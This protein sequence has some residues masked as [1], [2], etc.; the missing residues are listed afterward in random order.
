MIWISGIDKLFTYVNQG[1]LEFTGRTV[2]QELGNGW[3]ECVHP[4]DL[5]RCLHT[6]TSAFEGPDPFQM[7]YR[8]RRHDGEYRWMLDHGVPTFDVNGSFTGYIGS[9]VDV[10]VRKTAE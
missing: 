8:L 5:E 10:T 6:Y 4:D 9:C 7:E 1:W 2:E 3:A